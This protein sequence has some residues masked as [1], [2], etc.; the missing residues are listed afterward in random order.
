MKTIDINIRFKFNMMN[1]N[2]IL[3]N[4]QKRT[5]YAITITT[6][7]SDESDVDD[8]RPKNRFTEEYS[9]SHRDIS[10]KRLNERGAEE[11]KVKAVAEKRMQVWED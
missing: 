4:L 1:N 8:F 5:N 3:I 7:S 6:M 10:K 9:D 2:G 11:R